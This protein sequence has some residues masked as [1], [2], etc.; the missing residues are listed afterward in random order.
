MSAWLGK[1]DEGMRISR[2]TE[3]QCHAV[4]GEFHACH[5]CSRRAE[6]I[7]IHCIELDLATRDSF[8]W[9]TVVPE[10]FEISS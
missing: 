2:L 4:E 8:Y 10:A 5:G 9:A 3:M 7:D 6:A 1:G